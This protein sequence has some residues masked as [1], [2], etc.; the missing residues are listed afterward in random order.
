[1]SKILGINHFKN[2]LNDFKKI[3]EVTEEY[4]FR[5][6]EYYTDLIQSYDKK[7]PIFSQCFPQKKELQDSSK[8]SL[9]PF[10][11]KQNQKIESFIHR[12]PN[13]GVLLLNN[14][15]GVNCRHCM[16]KRLWDN[17]KK[18]ISK[19]RIDDIISYCIKEEINDVIISGGDPLMSSPELL[20]EV[21][22]RLSEVRNIKVIRIGSRIPVVDPDRINEKIISI[23]K[24]TEKLHLLT[25]FNHPKEVT[26]LSK[27]YI[28]KI[29]DTGTPVFN[30]TVLLKNINDS[31]STL[32][33]LFMKLLEIKIKPYYLHQC[34]LVRGVTHFWVEPS[35]GIKLLKKM[36][37]LISGL[38]MPYYAI[39]LPG[40][41]GKVLLGPNS[42]LSKIN[43]KYIL[44]NYKN[45][46]ISYS[47]Y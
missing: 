21:V 35:R 26:D 7:D 46:T 37:G 12:Y 18:E 34:D 47:L 8:F 38:A 19:D 3:K 30:Q 15:C 10:C 28:S 25:H 36:E 5:I 41:K 44:K 40:G 4:P 32:S 9:D 13:K 45:E 6:T 17:N 27:C 42:E 43:G 20:D 16:R 24:K 2:R 11:E 23:F 29:V 1:M 14:I 31:A 39:D 33:E 22:S